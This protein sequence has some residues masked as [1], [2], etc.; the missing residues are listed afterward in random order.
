MAN[1]TDKHKHDIANY[2]IEQGWECTPD[3]VQDVYNARHAPAMPNHLPV[4]L[5]ANIIHEF[6]RLDIK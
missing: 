5:A 6:D 3:T 1:L 4:A 2:M